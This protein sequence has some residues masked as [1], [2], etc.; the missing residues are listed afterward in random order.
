MTNCAHCQAKSQT[1]LCG[2]C[3]TDLRD[4]LMGL[5]RG[6]ELPTGQRAAG[7][8]EYLED[9]AWGR[10]RKGESARRSSECS[11]PLPVNLG[12]SQ[13]LENVHNTLVG[14]VRHLCE[15]R[16]VEVA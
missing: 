13:L 1:F 14:W 5:V 4:M 2:P 15:S 10:S 16:G 3:Q 9:E 6:Q 7:F 8:I 11:K 12:A